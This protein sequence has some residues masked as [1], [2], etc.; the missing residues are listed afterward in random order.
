MLNYFLVLFSSLRL[1][2]TLVQWELHEMD[3]FIS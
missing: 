2:L 1:P 3:D